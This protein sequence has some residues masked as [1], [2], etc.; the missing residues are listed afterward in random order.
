MQALQIS[1]KWIN[2]DELM[3]VLERDRPYWSADGGVTFGGGEPLVQKDFAVSMLK[4]CRDCCI[5]TALE[6][7]L[8]IPPQ[9]LLE[10]L[11]YTDFVFA[12][13]KH[14]NDARHR[15]ATGV[16]NLPIL[17]NLRRIAD[18]QWDGRI[19]I[20]CPIIPGFNDTVENAAATATFMDDVG[21]KEINLLPFHRLGYSKYEQ[22]GIAY[23]F[24]AQPAVPPEALEDL[25]SI[26]EANNVICYIGS[27]T[28]F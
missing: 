21:F 8:Y 13:I 7:C 4:R 22:L 23:D 9:H 27:D 6:T 11:D 26:Y 20:R 5:H 10:A 2:A 19:V 16:S 25:K 3:K 17:C 15:E 1:G 12:D 14:M 18:S 24:A 28:P